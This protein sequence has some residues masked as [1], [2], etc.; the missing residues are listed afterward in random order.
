MTVTV[1]H[2][3]V[4]AA[5]LT[6]SGTFYDAVLG[7][8]GY[9]RDNTYDSLIVYATADGG[10][11]LLVYRVEGDDTSRHQHGTPGLQHIALQV[12]NRD[13]V[14]AAHHA[15][16]TAGGTIIH[17]A[18]PFH[19]SAGYYATFVED[20]DGTRLEIAHIPVPVPADEPDTDT[21]S[22]S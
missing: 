18:Q 2:V 22:A 16:A 21:Q 14:D 3:A 17:A 13:V 20:P 11:E 6:T 5:D 10:P 4:T 15:A 8:L 12:D 19:Y 9:H 7:A 1:H